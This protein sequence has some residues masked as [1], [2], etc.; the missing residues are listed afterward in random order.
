MTGSDFQWYNGIVL[1]FSFFSVRLVWGIW[2]TCHFVWDSIRVLKGYPGFEPLTF[3]PSL[4]LELHPYASNKPLPAW[5][6]A[7]F[8]LSN[9]VLN[10]LNI[11]WFVKMIDAVFKRFR[12]PVAHA[13]TEEKTEKKTT[14]RKHAK[15][16]SQEIVLEAATMLEAS[17]PGVE[18]AK[19]ANV[20]PPAPAPG[21]RRR[22][23]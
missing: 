12:K 19:D 1:L 6:F 13:V 21:F 4:P 23:G 14:S 8:A 5:I 22:R 18:V 3:F 20:N 15:S 7:C 9:V 17:E 2:Q 10:I 16:L 11:F